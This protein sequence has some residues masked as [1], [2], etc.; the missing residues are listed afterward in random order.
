MLQKIYSR[1]PDIGRQRVNTHFQDQQ[2]FNVNFLETVKVSGKM[3][4]TTLEFDMCHR[5][6]PLSMFYSM[7]LTYILP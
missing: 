4:D 3:H 5:M 2:F 6:T 1:T 7:T